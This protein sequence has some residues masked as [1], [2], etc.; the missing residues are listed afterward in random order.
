M[1]INY[2]KAKIGKTRQNYKCRLFG[3]K[4]EVINPISECSKL[5]QKEYKSRHDWMGRVT[6]KELCKKIKFVATTKW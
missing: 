6:H 2:I 1:T 5:A 4:D 3:D